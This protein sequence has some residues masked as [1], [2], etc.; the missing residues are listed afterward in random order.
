[1]NLIDVRDVLL[2]SKIEPRKA[3]RQRHCWLCERFFE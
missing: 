2:K 1:V 3:L